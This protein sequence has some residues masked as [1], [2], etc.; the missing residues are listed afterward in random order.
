M[1]EFVWRVENLKQ[2]WN[3][4]SGKLKKTRIFGSLETFL[5]VVYSSSIRQLTKRKKTSESIWKRTELS[6]LWQR[7][8]LNPIQALSGSLT[9][10]LSSGRIVWRARKARKPPWLF[11]S[12]SQQFGSHWYRGFESGK[13]CFEEESIRTWSEVGWNGCCMLHIRFLVFPKPNRSA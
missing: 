3:E 12:G 8:Y 1:E 7:V 9:R 5:T 4:L 11:E 6:M 2:F 13:R 10:L